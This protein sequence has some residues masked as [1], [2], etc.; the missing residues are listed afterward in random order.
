VLQQAVLGVDLEGICYCPLD[1]LLYVAEEYGEKLY[2]VD[3]EGLEHVG[4][5]AYSR[6]YGGEKLLVAGGN[7]AEGIEWIPDDAEPAAG[8]FLLLNQDDPHCLFRLNH[9][10][11][12]FSGKRL[13]PIRAWW[14]TE[15]I[16]AGALHYVQE[17]RT[18][19]LIHSWMNVMEYIDIDTMEATGFEVFPGAAQEAVAIDGEGRL[20]VGSDLGGIARYTRTKTGEAQDVRL[21]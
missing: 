11:L 10:D 19:W 2:A 15:P 1:G 9:E 12:D 17:E 16:N 18:L 8:F 3:P 7:G 6:E 13:A 20:W 4:T 5:A 21:N 14:P